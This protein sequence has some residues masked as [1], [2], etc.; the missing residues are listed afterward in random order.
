MG[1]SRPSANGRYSTNGPRRLR[2][3]LAQINV[4]VGDLEGNLALIERDLRRAAKAGARLVAF[5]ELAL[6]GYPP[7]DLLLKPG[8]IRDNL[9]AL[10]ALAESSRT[11]PELTVVVGFA[12]RDVDLFNAA[13]I[14]RNGQRVDT[15]H[16]QFLPNYGVFDEDRYFSA[17][18]RAP[19]YDL[20]GVLVGVNICEDIWYP[21]GPPTEQ[22]YA[23]AE[24]LLNISSSPFHVGKQGGRERMLA[25]RAADT[26]SFVAYV[27]L[28]G[29]QDEL[30]FD[31]SSTVFNS[32]GDLVARAKSF[33]E[34]LLVVD[35]DVDEVFRTRLHDPLGRKERRAFAA[36]SEPPIVVATAPAALVAHPAAK[37]VRSRIEP[38]P[39]PVE[40][41]YRALVLGTRDYVRK[42]GFREAVVALSGGIDS[43][44]TAA[45]AVDALGADHV[46]GVSMPSRYS[47]AGSTDDAREL[48]E[49]LGIRYT[50][51]PIESMFAAALDTL[52]ET[53]ASGTPAAS[54]LAEE[55]LQARIRGML[56][57]ALSNRFGAIVLTTGNKSEVAVGYATLYGDMAG[58]FAVLKDVFKTLVYDLARWRNAQ[59]GRALIPEN[60]I[61]KPP[62]AELR[63][64]Q[65]DTDSLPPYEILDPILHAY[66][67]DD[68]DFR[69]IVAQGYDAETVRRVMT[70]VDKSEYKRRQ[71]PPGIKIT[72][73]AFG[74]DRRLPLTS[75]YRGQP[76]PFSTARETEARGH[77]RRA[78]RSKR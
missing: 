60:T 42:N 19:I 44:L 33:E 36:S 35:L 32:Q 23:G 13:A 72:G 20:G 47:S 77:E 55:N 11:Y 2:V 51:L 76:T 73:R 28:V 1:D 6:T 24:V 65:Q 67:E 12:D 16:K 31:G 37:A 8:F 38:L 68:W 22:A 10:E 45:I 50:T 9:R 61:T 34:D 62:S 15:Y 58:G 53:F 27:N 25:T 3:A 41:A 30:M 78:A 56:L 7:E 4:T 14:I 46:W 57:M 66:V 48:A 40:E 70:L 52:R 59:A 43:A 21:G 69:A 17:G 63:P 5:P 75:A 64:G 18:T 49:H 39:A 29:G 54:S 26:G 71:A 74:R